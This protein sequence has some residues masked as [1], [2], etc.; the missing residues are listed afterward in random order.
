MSKKQNYLYV[1]VLTNE[2]PK[3]VTGIG[4]KKTAFWDEDKKPMEFSESYAKDLSFGLLVNFY[5]A[6][7]ICSPIELDNQPYYYSKGKFEWIWND[8]KEADK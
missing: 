7:A 4:E 1:I 8:E 2:G 5:A 6:Y 3:F